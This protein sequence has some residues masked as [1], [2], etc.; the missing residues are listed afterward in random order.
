M[1]MLYEWNLNLVNGVDNEDILDYG[2]FA[3]ENPL[4]SLVRNLHIH[5]YKCNISTCLVV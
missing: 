5:V 4:A 3:L 2:G 1:I